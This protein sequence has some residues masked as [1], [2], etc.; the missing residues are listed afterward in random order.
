MVMTTVSHVFHQDVNKYKVFTKRDP[1][2][3]KSPDLNWDFC[4]SS[5]IRFQSS[6]FIKYV[7]L[8]IY[9]CTNGNI[10]CKIYT[11]YADV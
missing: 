11:K 1:Q 10:L 2:F 5:A 9:K 3:A 7:L 4:D 8:R 6:L